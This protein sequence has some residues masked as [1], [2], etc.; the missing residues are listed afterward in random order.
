MTYKP[1]IQKS[2]T[3]IEYDDSSTSLRGSAF[4]SSVDVTIGGGN[5]WAALINITKYFNTYTFSP[6]PITNL[7][8]YCMDRR[9]CGVSAVNYGHESFV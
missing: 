4:T 3:E 9:I 1:P 2:F 8:L 5:E 7:A 6:I